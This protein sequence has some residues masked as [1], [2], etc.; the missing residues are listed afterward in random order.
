M[1]RA[2]FWKTESETQPRPYPAPK[3]VPCT[4]GPTSSPELVIPTSAPGQGDS[5]APKA[6]AKRRRICV[7]GLYPDPPRKAHAHAAALLQ[8]I[9]DECP[10]KIGKYIPHAHLE[11]TYD[12]L[13][14]MEGWARLH[15]TALGR[16]L[17]K[18]TDRKKV[19]RN[20]K[21]LRV[22]RIPRRQATAY[23]IPRS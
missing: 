16:E 18:L 17:G 21:A 20:G 8:L 9:C 23:R 13:C 6:R 5:S 7:E 14:R 22:Y 11:R 19:K 1:L 10:E 4:V 2:V 15:W 12:E 3:P